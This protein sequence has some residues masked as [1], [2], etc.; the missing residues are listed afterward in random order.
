MPFELDDTYQPPEQE[1]TI[2]KP[3]SGGWIKLYRQSLVNGWLTNPYLW[4][5]F[6]YCLLKAS[7]KPHTAIVGFQKVK[8]DAGQFIFGRSQAASDLKMSER[9][10]RTCQNLLISTNTLSVKTTNKFSIITIVNWNSYQQTSDENDQQNDQLDGQRATNNR[11]ASD[12]LPATYNKG[13]KEEN[14]KKEKKE[15]TPPC[16]GG[17]EVEKFLSYFSVGWKQYAPNRPLTITDKHHRDVK[18]MLVDLP[19][20][21]KDQP[22]NVLI[23]KAAQFFVDIMTVDVPFP[24]SDIKAPV[25]F[26]KSRMPA[27]APL[28]TESVSDAVELG[29]W[30]KTDKDFWQWLQE[31]T[32]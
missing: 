18:A 1:L 17:G 13:K 24:D 29:L 26:F 5:F 10:I 11:P 20:N 19:L 12:Q 9:K 2:V 28:T 6:S 14:E 25:A 27:Q 32:S 15:N 8:L 3:P 30:P 7:H 4:A 31:A 22:L 23:C 16:D 21:S